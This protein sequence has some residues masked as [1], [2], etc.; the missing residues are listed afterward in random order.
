MR[1]H[2]GLALV[3]V[4]TSVTGVAVAGCS[5]RLQTIIINDEA[6]VSPE[7]GSSGRL[8]SSSGDSGTSGS[9]GSSGTS[10]SS[11]IPGSSGSS[12]TPGSSGSS[13]SSGSTGGTCPSTTPIDATALPYKNPAKS[14]GS[15]TQAEVNALANY[16]SANPGA[17][18]AQWKTT[19]VP[20]QT[21]RACIFG[22]QSAATWAPLVEDAT[23]Q[24]S[25]LNVGGCIAIATNNNA[26]GRAYQNWFD[27]RF[28]ACAGCPSGNNTAFQQCL[29][30][31]SKG[32]CANAVTAVDTAC[33]AAAVQTAETACQPPGTKFV[34]EGPAK[35]QCVG[36]IP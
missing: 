18:Y 27:C 10:G 1:Q 20:N 34:F 15:C 25:V 5:S 36:G 23:A 33:T 16:V 32:A 35:A 30:D 17:S 22:P 2:L 21:C 3:V 26:C 19:G 14:I 24:L 6:G 12:G 4:A 9:S 7:G 29:T 28:A 11:G 8:P 31:A 13:G